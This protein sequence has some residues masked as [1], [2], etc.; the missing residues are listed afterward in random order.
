VLLDL[1]SPNDK[2]VGVQVKSSRD[3]VEVSQIAPPG[4]VRLVGDTYMAI[5]VAKSICDA[6]MDSQFDHPAVVD[7][8]AVASIAIP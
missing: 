6:R 1:C 2:V 8:V 4:F 7:F 5:V 3:A